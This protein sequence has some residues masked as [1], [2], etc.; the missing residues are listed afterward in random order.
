MTLLKPCAENMR[1]R[2]CS[3]DNLLKTDFH[4]DYNTIVFRNIV[5]F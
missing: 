1:K 3:R 4:I 2:F 5:E